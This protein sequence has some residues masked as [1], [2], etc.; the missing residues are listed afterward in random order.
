MNKKIKFCLTISWILFSRSY[1]AYCTYALTPDL[2]KEANPLSTVVG[3]SS[4]TTLLIILG[5]LTFYS[6]YA[7]F[8]RTFRPMNL[9]PTHK[10]MSFGNF[11][12]YLYLGVEKSWLATLYQLPKDLQRF[13]N[14]MGC[15]LTRGLVFAGIVS[16]SMWLLIHH[17][18]YY[19]DNHSAPL[20]YSI[21]IGGCLVIMYRWNKSMY[22]EYQAEINM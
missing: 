4:W 7:Y 15:L 5:L 17:S 19:K 13:S 1:D 10:D 20:V 8:V 12:A 9:I 2:S 3:I 18:E 14:Y 6:M 16:T 11:V 21:L 22:K